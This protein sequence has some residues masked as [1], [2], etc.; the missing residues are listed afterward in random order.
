[1]LTNGML[2]REALVP[3]DGRLAIR[4]ERIDGAVEA[5]LRDILEI[6]SNGSRATAEAYIERNRGWDDRH[7]SIAAA[8]R[9]AEG[10]RFLRFRNANL[11]D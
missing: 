10:Q 11:E 8:V 2:D 9:A 1:M 4:Y 7:E 3:V 6:Q 5:M